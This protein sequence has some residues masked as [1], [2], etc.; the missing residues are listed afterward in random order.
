M[1]QRLLNRPRMGLAE[2]LPSSSGSNFGS[3]PASAQ[4]LFDESGRRRL[5]PVRTR[6]QLLAR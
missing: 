4:T 1:P 6:Q 3:R 5:F 2:N